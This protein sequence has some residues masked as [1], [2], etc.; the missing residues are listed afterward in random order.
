MRRIKLT[1]GQWALVD[2][3]DYALVSQFTWRASFKGKNIY[4]V[5]HVWEEGKDHSETMHRFILGVADP[6]VEVDHKDHNGLNN[7]R[8]NLRKATKQ[9]NAA[10]RLRGVV[11]TA[12]P[13][14]G[15]SWHKPRGKFRAYIKVNQRFLHLGLFS[16]EL[17]AAKAY[18]D[19]AVKFFGEFALLNKIKRA[20]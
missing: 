9:Q 13:H 12:S 20:V 10:N 5:R 15:V 19:A 18:N 17:D 7:R 8:Y 11:G 2:D 16:S 4:A 6:K 3:R 1:K 14:R